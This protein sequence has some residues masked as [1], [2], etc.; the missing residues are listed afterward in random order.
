MFSINHFYKLRT[1]LKTITWNKNSSGLN[2]WLL[3]IW[4]IDRTSSLM[5]ET[6][7][8]RSAAM[9]LSPRH[10]WDTR[11]RTFPF[12]FWNHKTSP[13]TLFDSWS[14][15]L[16]DNRQNVVLFV[17]F[18]RSFSNNNLL[19]TLILIT[20]HLSW[21]SG[22]KRHESSISRY[23]LQS[24]SGTSSGELNSHFSKVVRQPEMIICCEHCTFQKFTNKLCSRLPCLCSASTVHSTRFCDSTALALL[25]L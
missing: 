13:R 16:H 2:I 14:A 15:S 3:I 17:L 6:L 4:Y 24:C 9:S 7:Q 10:S 12:T 20:W 5:S 22:Q 19:P 25:A 23:L 21:Q 1:L 11:Q 18:W 8:Q